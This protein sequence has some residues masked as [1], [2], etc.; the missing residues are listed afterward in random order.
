ML[1]KIWVW[2]PGSGK[3]YSGV[4]IQGSPDPQHCLRLHN[5]KVTGL[6]ASPE[7]FTPVYRTLVVILGGALAR[8]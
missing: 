6:F 2:D 5:L 1:S 8:L 3:N 7:L 4:R